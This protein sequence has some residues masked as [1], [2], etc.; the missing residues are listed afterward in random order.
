MRRGTSARCLVLPS[1]P[2]CCRASAYDIVCS[3]PEAGNRLAWVIG[4]LRLLFIVVVKNR[5][6]S[7]EVATF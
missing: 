4:F 7:L 6:V 2:F 5:Q 1:L 3:L